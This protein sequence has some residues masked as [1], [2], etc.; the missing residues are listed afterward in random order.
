MEILKMNTVQN[1]DSPDQKK[2]FD[3]IKNEIDQHSV[4]VFMKGDKDFPLCGFSSLVVQIFRKMNVEFK[5]INIML[6]NDLRQAIKDFSNW[7]TIPQ[8]YIKG[9]FVGGS[10]ILKDMYQSGE[11]TELLSRHNLIASD[12][13]G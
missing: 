3:F 13:Q 4:V 1:I 8:I 2:I 9:E 6:S 7:P 12:I 11:L 10:D 5:D